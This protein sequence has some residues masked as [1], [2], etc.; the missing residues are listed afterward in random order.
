MDS[1]LF[2]I[3]ARVGLEMAW[4]E[5]DC[6]WLV[7]GAWCTAVNVGVRQ[8]AEDWKFR[9]PEE[10]ARVQMFEVLLEARA[11]RGKERRSILLKSLVFGS[12]HARVK[13]KRDQRSLELRG[14]YRKVL[15]A[16]LDSTGLW[17]GNEVQVV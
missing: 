9:T 6:D 12:T 3:P 17:K 13:K 2:S 14:Q 11:A 8:R 1:H 10:V 4:A 7:M 15:K 16:M 5:R